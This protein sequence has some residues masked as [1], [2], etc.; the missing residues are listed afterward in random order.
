MVETFA[1]N[2]GIQSRGR[3][4]R[5]DLLLLAAM[6]YLVHDEDR[7]LYKQ[8]DPEDD[9]LYLVKGQIKHAKVADE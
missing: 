3:Y 7:E 2:I 4:R 8:V 9:G 5:W 1:I 6:W